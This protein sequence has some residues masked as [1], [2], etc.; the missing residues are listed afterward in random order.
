MRIVE[1]L[2]EP[3]SR[4]AEHLKKTAKQNEEEAKH[5]SLPEAKR[6]RISAKTPQGVTLGSKLLAGMRVKVIGRI[7]SIWTSK[8]RPF[9]YLTDTRGQLLCLFEGKVNVVAPI[10]FQKQASLEVYGELKSVLVE[11][12]APGD[13]EL[14]VDY[15]KIIGGGPDSFTNVIPTGAHQSMLS[16]VRHLVLRRREE[17]MVMK[18]R[19]AALSAFRWY[20]KEHDMRE[21]TAP[22]FVQTQVEGGGS[23]FS[24]SYYGERAYLTQTS[25]LYLE[26]QIPVHGDCYTI[27]SSFRAENSHTRRHLLEYTYVEGELHFI[28]FEDLLN[29]IGDLLCGVIDILLAD[30]E[31]RELIMALNPE[32]KAPA[33]PFRRMRYTEA[34]EWLNTHEVMDEDRNPHR[35]ITDEIGEPIMFTHFPVPIKAFYMKKDAIDSRVTESADCL[36]SGVGEVVGSGMRMDDY[37]SLIEVMKQNKWDL[38]TYAF[39]YS[40]QRRYGSS[41]HGGYR[42]GI[43]RLLA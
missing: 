29:H 26:T 14:H 12:K 17:S 27:Q 40:D 18:A 32:F 15:H 42:M 37:D 23:L 20:Y 6:L 33:R 30:A 13:R 41:P 8:T 19:S 11:N 43:E 7:E 38:K 2:E 5:P 36:V 16:D 28:D 21:S 39:Y 22:S 9:V 1:E 3:A 34:I 10:L 24:L 35:R 4:H 31:S 25:Q